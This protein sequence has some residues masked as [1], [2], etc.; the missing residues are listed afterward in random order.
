MLTII[1]AV[2]TQLEPL[3]DQKGVYRSM[4]GILPDSAM[5]PCYAVSPV[6]EDRENKI[7]QIRIYGYVKIQTAEGPVIGTTGTYSSPG[8]PAFIEAAYDALKDDFLADL[9]SDVSP[10]E[11]SFHIEPFDKEVLLAAAQFEITYQKCG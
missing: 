4:E 8:I 3:L 1:N 6:S 10:G 7:Y 5:F 9:V 2:K 11:I